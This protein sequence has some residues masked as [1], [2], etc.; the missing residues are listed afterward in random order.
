MIIHSTICAILV[1]FPCMLFC[2]FGG[3][4]YLVFCGTESAFLIS[5]I[6]IIS[7]H[8]IPTSLCC[9]SVDHFIHAVTILTYDYKS[10]L[11]IIVKKQ[12]MVDICKHEPTFESSHSKPPPS[13]SP[14]ASC[15]FSSMFI[16]S[17]F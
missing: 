2:I 5:T 16:C 17:S 11:N 4:A 7:S 3:V 6:V 1:N 9:Y 12:S 8:N 10:T 13:E 14:S 15:F